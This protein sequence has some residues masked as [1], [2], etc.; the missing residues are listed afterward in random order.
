MPACVIYTVLRYSHK[1]CTLRQN[2]NISIYYLVKCQSSRPSEEKGF[3][4]FSEQT[5]LFCAI[6]GARRIVCEFWFVLAAAV[7][8]FHGDVLPNILLSTHRQ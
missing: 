1:S 5:A 6:F 2:Y 7:V 4:A 8:K 3:P